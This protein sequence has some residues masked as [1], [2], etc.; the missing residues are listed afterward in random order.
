MTHDKELARG[1][2]AKPPSGLKVRFQG[3][4]CPYRYLLSGVTNTWRLWSRTWVL[5]KNCIRKTL[6]V[7]S[8]YHVVNWLLCTIEHSTLDARKALYVCASSRDAC[9]RHLLFGKKAIHRL[10]RS[11]ASVNII[12]TV[13]NV[14]HLLLLEVSRCIIVAMVFLFGI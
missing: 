3:W 14:A 2:Q 10:G 12:S 13:L 7:A 4:A 11:L 1:Y 8:F 6:M 5:S 9:A